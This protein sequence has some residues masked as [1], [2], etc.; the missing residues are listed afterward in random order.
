MQELI[1]NW[2]G[3]CVVTRYDHASGAW[4]FIAIHDRT[5]GMA[6]GGCRIHKYASPAEGLRDALRLASGM[7]LKW[8][9]ID[10]PFGGGK[11]VLA[12]PG[13]LD[14][15]ARE[16]LL[17][18]FGD[19]LESLGGMYGTGVDLGTTPQDMNVIGSRSRWV[20]GRTPEH[21]G[22]GD[23]G[24]WTALGV[25]AG[26]RAAC[27][28]VFGD[29]SLAGRTV[30]LQGV[31]GVGAPLARRIV[32][33]G[34][35]LIITDAIPSRARALGDELDADV[36]APELAYETPCDIFAPCAIGG[37]LNAR[38]IPRLH[39]RIV[40]GSANNQIEI[41]SDAALLHEHG[42]LWVPDFVINAGGAIAYGA[43]EVLH[44]DAQRTE[45]RVAKIFDAVEEI[46]AEAD[47]RKESPLGEAVRRAERNLAR[48]RSTRQPS[49][50]QP[51]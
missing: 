44:W 35:K 38:S 33:G 13:P 47:R 22:A 12:V 40:A 6:M 29:A 37:I 39:C 50:L 11:A 3:E 36:V 45:Q 2:D 19:L 16:A 46:L 31:G 10:F 15:Q 20:C 27:A 34:A 30:L 1:R 48:A 32:A 5:L 9:A 7:T 28:H 8:A 43:L 49:E 14:P 41:D 24:P 42:V 4:I 18:R 26:I 17:L 21:G 23:A 25:H 51:A